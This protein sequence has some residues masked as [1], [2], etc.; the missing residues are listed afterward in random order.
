MTDDL[1]S[2]LEESRREALRRLGWRP[3][4]GLL[5]GQQVWET[6]DGNESLIESEAFARLE[7]L[8]KEQE[9]S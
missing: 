4:G 3:V 1:F 7:R 9:E 8:E 2:S 5:H 6:P